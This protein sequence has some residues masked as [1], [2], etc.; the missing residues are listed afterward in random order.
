M[1]IRQCCTITVGATFDGR[2]LPYQLILPKRVKDHE[3]KKLR[4]YAAS[5]NFPIVIA[6]SAKAYQ[7]SETLIDYIEHGLVPAL[8]KVN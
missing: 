7:T 6:K 1:L 8:K 3:I 4:D 5:Q 2:F